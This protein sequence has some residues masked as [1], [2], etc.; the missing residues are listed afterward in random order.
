MRKKLQILLKRYLIP[1]YYSTEKDS[2]RKWHPSIRLLFLSILTG[3]VAEVLIMLILTSLKSLPDSLLVFF[4][5]TLTVLVIFPIM[6][7][8]LVRPL[9]LS[10]IERKKAEQKLLE[11]QEYYRAIVEDQ[12]EFIVRFAPDGKITF[13]N[14]ASCWYFNVDPEEILGKDVYKTI[15]IADAD[16]LKTIQ[17][18]LTVE[19]PVTGAYTQRY[20]RD[21]ETIRWISWTIRALYDTKK[22]V[23]QYQAVG[24]DTTERYIIQ[25]ELQKAYNELETRV[26]EH[27]QELS[28]TLKR[29]RLMST[30]V[31]S[32]ANG[33][34]VTDRNG[35]I[36]WVNPAVTKIAGYSSDELINRTPSILKSG[37]QGAEFYKELWDTITSG[38]VWRGELVNRRKDGSLYS[39]EQTI[40]PL[41]DDDGNITHFIAIVQDISERRR[42]EQEV[43]QRSMELQALHTIST[44][45]SR[46]LDD[47]EIISTL[48]RL[49]EEE[50]G[51]PGGAV[52]LYD[53]EADTLCPVSS[54]GLPEKEPLIDRCIPAGE[55]HG[56]KA[57]REKEV[58]LEDNFRN[59]EGLKYASICEERPN[60][61]GYLCVPLL[62]QDKV[63]GVLDLFKNG[64][65]GILDQSED[66]QP[67]FTTRE[68][69]FYQVLGNEIGVAVQNAKLFR[70]EQR[71]RQMSE[72]IEATSLAL[73][74]SL[75]L[76]AVIE[77][78]LNRLEDL[79]PYDSATVVLRQDEESYV[80]KASRGYP[81][82][83]ENFSIRPSEFPVIRRM[84]ETGKS[85]LVDDTGREPEW[86]WM[87]GGKRVRNWLG[88]PVA[89]GGEVIGFY[90]LEKNEAGFFTGQ[91]VW[92][93]EAIVGQVAIAVQNA[94]LF[95]QLRASHES[96]QTMSRRL[97]EIQETERSY[98]ARELHDEAGQAL[99][100]LM[101]GLDLISKRAGDPDAVIS[102]IKELEHI[103]DEVLDNLHRMAMSLR[104]A[105][106]D[107]LG[108]TAALSQY[109][110][111]IGEKHGLKVQFEAVGIDVRL[112]HEME[113]TIYRIVQEAVSNAVRHAQASRIDVLLERRGSQGDTKIIALI[114]DNG[115]GFIPEES[116]TS[117][118]LGLFGMRERAEMLDGSLTIESS[119]GRG[120]TILAEIPFAHVESE[121]DL[122]LTGGAL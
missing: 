106:L 104:P 57:V 77:T 25:N 66:Y 29:I 78:L 105:S 8:F 7:F 28:E 52:Y 86:N 97:V 47:E 61:S 38:K 4:D 50:I 100:S 95:N 93:A 113:T 51:V 9:N 14:Q 84:L 68:V 5:V 115:I 16:T 74:Q 46:S 112:P 72:S 20:E 11:N 31:S 59:I 96:M 55:F 107:H 1:S 40:T 2:L 76:N 39:E 30:A 99:A 73:T 85:L 58:V 19:E 6:F 37:K 94:W 67:G 69:R 12:T 63:E 79:I 117:G 65:Q 82:P 13:A 35:I 26:R 92:L 24:R 56:L 109:A 10:I 27:T 81:E 22:Q 34:M 41:V 44:A 54:W 121:E 32:A 122:I 33:I 108:L 23:Y 101:L 62:A 120:T 45:C 42:V 3:A 103:V 119:P 18:T 88:V 98:I 114:E 43:K 70:K 102:G 21:P 111:A 60:W 49:L 80:C 71:A 75:N 91:D 89:A 90:T 83:D 110:Q 64:R 118:R 116:L 36:E 15:C 17:E 48:T 87:A 53:E